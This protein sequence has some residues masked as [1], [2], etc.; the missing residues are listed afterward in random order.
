MTNRR[1]FLALL[2]V[3]TA[4]APLAAKQALEAEQMKLA[5]ISGRI[6]SGSG[7]IGYADADDV[8][9][10]EAAVRYAKLFGVPSHVERRAR[11]NAQN[12]HSLDADIACKR[13]WS[14][15]VKVQEQRQRNYDS[16][17][18][19]YR[20]LNSYGRAQAAFEKI[21]GFKWPW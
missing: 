11:E 12:V 2:G 9:I 20:D 16:A 3:G 18:A 8:K 10:S 19:Y 7:E 6:A 15:C 17:M 1:R 4:S 14:L 5:G 13:S 21:S